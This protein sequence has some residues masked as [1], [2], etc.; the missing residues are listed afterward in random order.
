MSDVFIWIL[1]AVIGWLLASMCVGAAAARW[2]RY[3][4]D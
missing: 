3:L 4:R 2:F 1:I